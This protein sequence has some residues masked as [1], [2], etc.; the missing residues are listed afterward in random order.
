MLQPV[1]L[2]APPR[3]SAVAR[4]ALVIRVVAGAIVA[5]FGV[6]KFTHHDAEAAALDRYGIPWADVTTYLVGLVELGSGT[7]LVLG[8]LT[9]SG[10]ALVSASG[11]R[12]LQRA[13]R[14]ISTAFVGEHPV[15]SAGR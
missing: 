14:P 12:L 1:A 8:L 13:G 15:D 10:L 5:G 2:L 9:V 11:P 4:A 6:G 3:S 7:L